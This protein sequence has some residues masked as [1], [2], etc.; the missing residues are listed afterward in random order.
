MLIELITAKIEIQLILD[1]YLK[2]DIFCWLSIK[3]TIK[4]NGRAKKFIGK[5]SINLL[6]KI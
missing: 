5:P 2:W 3:S 4:S 1:K 6:L